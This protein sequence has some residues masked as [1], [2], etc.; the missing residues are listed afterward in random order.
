MVKKTDSAKHIAVEI[1]VG[2]ETDGDIEIVIKN[3]KR[4]PM[5]KCFE[6]SRC[7]ADFDKLSGFDVQVDLLAVFAGKNAVGRTRVN[8]CSKF[9]L[10][11]S[12]ADFYVERN[13][14]QV[15]IEFNQMGKV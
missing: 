10:I 5:L 8:L 13:S 1:L 6:S 11:I 3:R 2:D 15:G 12:D 7:R 14:G 9:S 4:Y